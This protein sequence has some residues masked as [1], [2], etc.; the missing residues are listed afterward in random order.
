MTSIPGW[1]L[2]TKPKISSKRSPW[3]HL[4]R[5]GGLGMEALFKNKFT[6]SELSKALKKSMSENTSVEKNRFLVSVIT[7]LDNKSRNIPEVVLVRHW[8]VGVLGIWRGGVSWVKG[9]VNGV[10]LQATWDRGGRFLSQLGG[11]QVSRRGYKG[12]Q[13]GTS[14]GRAKSQGNCAMYICNCVCSA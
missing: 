7:V 9:G 8:A 1:N 10:S 12:G 6:M 4:K 3:P 13:W 5:P 2:Y 14:K 11:C